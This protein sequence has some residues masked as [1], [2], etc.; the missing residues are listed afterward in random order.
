MSPGLI[1]LDG[2]EEGHD[3][4][5]TSK[6]LRFQG[7]ENAAQIPASEDPVLGVVGAG[8][9]AAEI[10]L[11]QRVNRV[12][13]VVVQGFFQFGQGDVG[14]IALVVRAEAEE[15]LETNLG[16][17]LG[18]RMLVL[19]TNSNAFVEDVTWIVGGDADLEGRWSCWIP[20]G[21]NIQQMALAGASGSCD[22][23][24]VSG[25]TCERIFILLRGF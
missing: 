20:W 10:Y 12:G 4:P 25:I 24:G 13:D 23:F 17:E 16:R 2:E 19:C 21:K 18:G 14:E 1:R 7:Q 11:K 3:R 8:R 6:K 22:N 9:G 15:R 5:V